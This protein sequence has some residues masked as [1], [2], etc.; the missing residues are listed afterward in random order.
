MKRLSIYVLSLVLLFNLSACADKPTETSVAPITTPEEVFEPAQITQPQPPP[1][2]PPPPQPEVSSLTIAAIGDILLHEPV[3]RAAKTAAGYNFDPMF[4]NIAPILSKPDFLIANQE[5]LPGGTQLGLSS[6]PT[7][8]S[9]QEIVDAE[10]KAGVDFIAE[11]NNHVLDKGSAGVLSAI[12]FY[13]SKNIPY[14]G[15][16]DSPEDQNTLRIQTINGVKVGVITYTYGTN[17][18]PVPK[19]KEYLVNLIDKDKMKIEIDRLKPEADVIVA[20]MHWG[21]EY[22]RQ[23]DQTQRD[24]AQFL[25]D[26]GVQIIFGSHPHVLQP[27]EWITSSTTGEQTLCVYSLGNFISNQQANYKDIGGMAQVQ[28]TLTKTGDQKKVTLGQVEFFPTYVSRKGSSK[29]LIVPMNAAPANG[30]SSPTETDIMN[31]MIGNLVQQ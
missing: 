4:Q 28:V 23:P 1:P 14:S 6:Y 2:P 18:I 16:Y 5:S 8:N 21:N 13:R 31:F 7:F 27:I 11:A 17:G 26:N 3:Y 25:A 22:Q 10:L 15:M 20:V 30:L 19:G 12:Q 29:Y 9:P 24:L